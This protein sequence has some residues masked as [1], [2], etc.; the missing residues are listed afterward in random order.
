MAWER[1]ILP[2]PHFQIG[3]SGKAPEVAGAGRQLTKQLLICVSTLPPVRD[4]ASLDDSI[5]PAN[6]M[7]AKPIRFA[8]AGQ[9]LKALPTGRGSA[10]LR[11]TAPKFGEYLVLPDCHRPQGYCGAHL[12]RY[13]QCPLT[14]HALSRCTGS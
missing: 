2:P 14:V 9:G 10:V 6:P 7:D 1:I 11:G 4:K 5:A 12:R 3:E 8:D 13:H